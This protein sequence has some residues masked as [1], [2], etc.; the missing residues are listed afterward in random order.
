MNKGLA[1]ESLT[2]NPLNDIYTDCHSC[3]PYDYIGR[4]ELFTT[5]LGDTPG[6]CAT[7]TP[8]PVSNISSEPPYGGFY[9]P[10]NLVSTTQSLQPFLVISAMLAILAFFMLGLVWM[11]RHQI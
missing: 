9:T 7:P 8:V 3:H 4:A 1:H 6:S 5:T 11:D 10:T 2:A